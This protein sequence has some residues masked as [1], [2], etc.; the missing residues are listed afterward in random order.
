MEEPSSTSHQSDSHPPKKKKRKP[1]S[2]SISTTLVNAGLANPV[3]VK[4]SI[5]PYTRVTVKLPA[6]SAPADLQHAT[7]SAEA[8]A[9]SE[10]R[11]EAGYYWGYTVRSAN[12]LSTVFTEC[13]YDGGYDLT[14]G[15]SERG[16]PLSELTSPEAGKNAIPPYKH[17][18][19]V[20]GGVAGLEAAVKADGELAAMGV[21][22][23]EKLFDYWVN[24]CPGQG[25]RTIR[26]EEAVWLG[27]MGLRG[28]VVGNGGNS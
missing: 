8:V 11:E 17:M 13:T 28:V 20:F 19:L 9:P 10:P 23:A 24:L 6:A 15:M 18:L 22:E 27:L 14:F 12:S 3:T 2:D 25:S 21:V 26:T 1:P 16:V 5:P 4:G 7:L